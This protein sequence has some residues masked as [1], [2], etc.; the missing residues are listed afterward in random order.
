VNGV[1]P[2]AAIPTTTSRGPTRSRSISSRPNFRLS[3]TGE[4]SPTV[5]VIL[6]ATTARTIPGS[7]PNVG[8]TSMASSHPNRPLV[9][10]PT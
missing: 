9:P 8:G 3:S 5:S 6:P 7:T 10:A 2:L 1:V 4:A